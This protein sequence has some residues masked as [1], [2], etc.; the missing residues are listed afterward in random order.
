MSFIDLESPTGYKENKTKQN[1]I[2]T[3]IIQNLT[4]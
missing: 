4:K 3:K 1:L 2:H